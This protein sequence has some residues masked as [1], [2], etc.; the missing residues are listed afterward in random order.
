MASQIL[1]LI[2]RQNKGQVTTEVGNA[3][4]KRLLSQSER[5][6]LLI[7]CYFILDHANLI[8]LHEAAPHPLTPI[9]KSDSLDLP[10]SFGQSSH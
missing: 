5:L 2:K 1:D 8:I 4:G 7:L 6:I 10:F 9:L 3:R